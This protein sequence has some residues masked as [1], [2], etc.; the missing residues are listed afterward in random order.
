[1]FL[2][3][4]VNCFLVH[5]DDPRLRGDPGREESRV[6]LLLPPV[7]HHLRR[8]DHHRDDQPHRGGDEHPAQRVQLDTLAIVQHGAVSAPGRVP[9]T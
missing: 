8:Q 1:M 9:V 6:L 2:V 5:F 4:K 3:V 7:V